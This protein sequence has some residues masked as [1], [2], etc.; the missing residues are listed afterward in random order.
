[1]ILDGNVGREDEMNAAVT[2]HETNAAAT[3]Q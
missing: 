3:D 1:M 2:D